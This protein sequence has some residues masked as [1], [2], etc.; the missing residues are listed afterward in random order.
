[1]KFA[2]VVAE[3]RVEQWQINPAIHYNE[4][5]NFVREDFRPV[6]SSQKSLIDSLRCEKCGG[7]LY[8]LPERGTAECLRACL[9]TKKG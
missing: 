5:A 6:V 3:S 2:E 7:F 4:W 9:K 1:M 8:V